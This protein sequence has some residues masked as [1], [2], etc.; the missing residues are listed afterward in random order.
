MYLLRMSHCS[1]MTVASVI[2]QKQLKKNSP[3]T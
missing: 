3:I 1:A 2:K